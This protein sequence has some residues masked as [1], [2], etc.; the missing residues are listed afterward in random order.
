MQNNA[1]KKRNTHWRLRIAGRLIANTRRTFSQRRVKH[2]GFVTVC[3]FA[4]IFL[5][6]M[7]Q[8]PVGACAGCAQITVRSI[9]RYLCPFAVF[10]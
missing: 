3:G 6:L 10:V 9:K 1:Q 5:G 7:P 4:V 2:N 8:S